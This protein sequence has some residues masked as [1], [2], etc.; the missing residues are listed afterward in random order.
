MDLKV[1]AVETET[2]SQV[3]YTCFQIILPLAISYLKQMDLW[4][5]L[6]CSISLLYA[7]TI[8]P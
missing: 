8:Y 6:L 2:L 3:Y 4:A 7:I 1:I 5:V